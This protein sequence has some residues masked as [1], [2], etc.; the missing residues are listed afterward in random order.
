MRRYAAHYVCWQTIRPMSYVETS[1][2]IFNGVY[3]LETE[4]H[5]TKFYN[6][7]LVPLPHGA[8][9]LPSHSPAD[10]CRMSAVIR[11]GSP[12]ALWQIHEDMARIVSH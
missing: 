5:S 8:I 6:G 12:F 7:I 4:P 1:E 9:P 2:G 11:P 3:P 10:L